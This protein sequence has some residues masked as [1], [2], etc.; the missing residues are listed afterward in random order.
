[1]TANSTQQIAFNARV[2][3]D[4]P[5]PFTVI[6]ERTDTGER[7]EADAILIGNGSPAIAL[8]IDPAAASTGPGSTAIFTVTLANLGT[9]PTTLDLDVAG[10]AGWQ[11]DLTLF[12][13]PVDQVTLAPT[14]LD[15]LNL[16][17]ALTPPNNAIV[18]AYPFTVAAIGQSGGGQQPQAIAAMTVTGTVQVIAQGVQIDIFSGP[19]SIA[20]GASGTWQ[21]QVK[22]AGAQADTFDLSTFGPLSLGGSI[23]PNSVTL[24]PG[25]AQ[26]VQLQATASTQAQAGTLLLGALA[27][28]HSANAVRDEDSIE[29]QVETVRAAAAQWNPNSLLIV[30]GTLGLA[31]LTIENAGNVDTTLDVSLNSIA[32]VTA[33]LPFTQ[34]AL[35]P[36]GQVSLPV[37]VTGD[38][39]GTYTLIATVTGG[40]TPV[41]ASLTLNVNAAPR[42]L[43]LPLIA[44]NAVAVIGH[45]YLPVIFR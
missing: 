13:Q 44:N 16:Q 21:V 32:H 18:G 15:T 3:G 43:Y 9:A 8:T 17:L 33:T 34:V 2:N 4:G 36:H 10:P 11:S 20:P 1:V 31:N 28:S 27:Q 7:A 22:N 24:S 30:S 5:H 12:G 29:V 42:L 26:T 14:G 19:T 37:N 25:Q 40:A 45:L 6:A 39:T 35:P 41:Q 23:I 38:Y